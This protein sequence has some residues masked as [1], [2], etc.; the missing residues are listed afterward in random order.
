MIAAVMG[1]LLLLG[2]WLPAPVS[3]LLEQASHIVEGTQ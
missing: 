3:A 1:A 2:L